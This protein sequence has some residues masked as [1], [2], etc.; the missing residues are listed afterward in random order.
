MAWAV[1]EPYGGHSGHFMGVCFESNGA[2]ACTDIHACYVVM[3]GIGK[4]KIIQT[5]EIISLQMAQSYRAAAQAL[6]KSES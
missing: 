2:L 3:R 4:K 6:F 5:V 1:I